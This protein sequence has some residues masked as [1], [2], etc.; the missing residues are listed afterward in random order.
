M[1][2]GIAGGFLS[3]AVV[4]GIGLAVLS[5]IAPPPVPFAPEAQSGPAVAMV[6]L[7]GASVPAGVPEP[8]PSVESASMEDAASAPASTPASGADTAPVVDAAAAPAPATLADPAPLPPAAPVARAEPDAAPATIV[9]PVA[10]PGAAAAPMAEAPPP[11]ALMPP[12]DAPANLTLP[13]S[14]AVPAPTVVAEAAPLAPVVQAA[15]A[16]SPGE[17]KAPDVLPPATARGAAPDVSPAS[18]APMPPPAPL[19]A[20]V[21]PA[22]AQP[23]RPG[24]EGLNAAPP[25]GPAPI[26][27]AEAPEAA[28]NATGG[29]NAAGQT[30]IPA[31][32]P[33]LPVSAVSDVSDAPPS[34]PAPQP[35]NAPRDLA[36]TPG[37]P[38]PAAQAEM[39]VIPPADTP[40]QPDPADLQP[41]E[42]VIAEAPPP[43]PILSRPAP[44]APAPGLERA[45]GVTVG[46]L[47]R[48]GAPPPEATAVAAPDATASGDDPD[49]PPLRRFARSFD[50]PA[51]KPLLAVVLIDNGEPT[52]D[53]NALAALPFPVTFALDPMMPGADL[54]AS[55]Y[56]DG[57]QE[58]AILAR[59]VPRGAQASD[60][61]VMFE[62]LARALPEAVAVMD[63]EGAGFQDNRVLSGQVVPVVRSQGRGLLSWDRGLNAAAQVARRE[64][65]AA[66]T[67][68]RRIDAEGASAPTMR[69]YLDRA[70]FKA[71]QDGRV[72]VAGTTEA[73][74]VAVLL[75]WLVEG[76]ASSVAIAPVSAVVRP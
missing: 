66:A 36:P 59:G 28:D 64:G 18:P 69:R 4:A 1:I 74:T 40:I 3:G 17:P 14:P 42:I 49:A 63:D 10:P 60:V 25:A 54:A 39:R 26:V 65:L 34:P 32:P 5:Q 30:D 61:E 21:Q 27:L 16:V 2:R 73:D 23:E 13:T 24:T 12:A 43:A 75:E 9:P 19:S 51:G 8:A 44:L 71:V 68:L 72:V 47:P 6:P 46:R 70:A 50:N 41:P 38:P 35:P 62:A 22:P 58:V 67:I 15:P 29:G 57:G 31:A 56:R 20:G 45:T 11:P 48:V 33:S 7:P 55:I 76:R 37:T 53:R 52:L